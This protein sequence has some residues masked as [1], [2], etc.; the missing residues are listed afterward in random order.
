VRESEQV[1]EFERVRVNRLSSEKRTSAKEFW[2]ARASARECERVL[3]R[4]RYCEPT[5]GRASASEC[6]KV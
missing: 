3:S 5:G 2:R 6:Q 4:M 1:L